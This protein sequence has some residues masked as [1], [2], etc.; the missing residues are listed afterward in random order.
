[1]YFTLN[2]GCECDGYVYVSMDCECCGTDYD[3]ENAYIRKACVEHGG[4]E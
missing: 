3:I 4:S 1:M 2:C